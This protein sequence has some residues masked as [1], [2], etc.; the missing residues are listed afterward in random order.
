MACFA[1]NFLFPRLVLKPVPWSQHPFRRFLSF[2]YSHTTM[3]FSTVT[4][5][6]LLIWTTLATPV[7]DD[8]VDALATLNEL[9][10]LAN[11]TM[12]DNLSNSTTSKRS[13]KCTAQNISVRKEWYKWPSVLCQCVLIILSLQGHPLCRGEDRL[14]RCCSLLP[15]KD[16]QYPNK[17]CS[18]RK[19]SLR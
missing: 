9:A 8:T 13:Q 11:Q 10:Q 19:V 4:I 15:E 1:S 2:Y 12:L 16:C 6:A 5:S 18:W 14:H 7:P 3:R 17:S